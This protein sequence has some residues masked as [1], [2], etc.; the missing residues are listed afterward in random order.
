MTLEIS[1]TELNVSSF[2]PFRKLVYT[3]N[4]TAL[5]DILVDL[6]AAGVNPFDELVEVLVDG[7]RQELKKQLPKVCE[8]AAKKRD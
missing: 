5:S 7:F 6:R 8:E 4:I 1:K 3:T 2:M